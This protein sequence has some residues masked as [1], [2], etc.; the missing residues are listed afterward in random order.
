MKPAM[1]MGRGVLENSPFSPFVSAWGT[2]KEGLKIKNRPWFFWSRHTYEYTHAP[3]TV[4]LPPRTILLNPLYLNHDLCQD[5]VIGLFDVRERLKYEQCWGFLI[6]NR[7]LLSRSNWTFQHSH[8]PPAVVLHMYH[9]TSGYLIRIT[10][11]ITLH[12]YLRVLV[13]SRCLHLRRMPWI[14]A[15]RPSTSLSGTRQR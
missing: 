14:G 4:M 11:I 15:G 9:P 7:H 5:H 10:C 1:K 12:I 2:K 8:T 3:S 6:R 13:T